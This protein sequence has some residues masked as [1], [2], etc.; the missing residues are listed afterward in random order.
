M[1]VHQTVSS[2]VHHLCLCSG[3]SHKKQELVKEL[4][5]NG[6][7]FDVRKLNVGDFLWV[8]REKVAPVPGSFFASCLFCIL[9]QTQTIEPLQLNFRPGSVS[10]QVSCELQP[11]ESWFW[12]TS[13]RGR[14]W[15]TCVAASST[16]ASG[17]RRSVARVYI[18]SSVKLQ[19][20]LWIKFL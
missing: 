10:P 8:A 20:I 13:S 1:C 16:D 17:N 3:S 11:A 2:S 6:V 12:I 19:I 14:G 7:S 15:T 4:Q 5:R 9:T 18:S